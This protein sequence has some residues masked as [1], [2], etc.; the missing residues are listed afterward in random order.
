MPWANVPLDSR[1]RVV[2]YLSVRD[3]LTLDVALTTT[4][5]RLRE[6]L[7]RAFQTAVIPAFD[8]YPFTDKDDFKGLRWVMRAGVKLHSVTLSLNAIAGTGGAAVKNVDDVLWHLVKRRSPTSRDCTPRRARQ[9]MSRR[10]GTLNQP[11]GWRQSQDTRL[12]SASD[13]RG[14]NIDKAR[15][16]GCTPLYIASAM[17]H[18]DVVRVLLEAGAD[19]D[20]AKDNGATPLSIAS[21]MGHVNVV[22]VLLEAGADINKA[23]DTGATP[24]YIA[25]EKGHV[26]VVKVLLE[27]GADINKAKDNGD[28]PLSI[29]FRK[30]HVDVVK[31]LEAGADPTK[32]LLRTAMG[33][34]VR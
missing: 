1:E 19:I 30:G 31:V 21:W 13:K 11:C 5:D 15:D 29:A 10:R 34:E 18:V 7:A 27:A 25:S 23:M 20:K 24:L 14:A 26:D 32:S 9:K 4:T 33:P 6:E 2:P 22:K 8:T 3:C 16:N 28:T 12:W 17:G